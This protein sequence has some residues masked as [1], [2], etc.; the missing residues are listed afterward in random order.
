MATLYRVLVTYDG[1]CF[2]CGQDN[3]DGLKMR[4]ERVGEESVCEFEVPQRYQSWRGMVH[5]G[6]VALL[7]DEAVG[8]AGWHSGRPG[9]TGR[10]EVRYRQPLGVGERV[11]VVGRVERVRRTLVY[12]SSYVDRLSDGVRIAEATATL[13]TAPTEVTAPR[14]G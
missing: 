2:G 4:F 12:A 7:L 1:R 9:L 10:L 5:G 14:P 13:M 3:D 6:M 11:R 8:W